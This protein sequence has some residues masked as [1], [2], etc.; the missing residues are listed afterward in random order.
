MNRPMY[1][2]L[3]SSVNKYMFVDRSVIC[4]GP[5]IGLFAGL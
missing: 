2:S 4:V 1:E 5:C 3:Y